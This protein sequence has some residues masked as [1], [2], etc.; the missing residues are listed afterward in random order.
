MSSLILLL[1]AVVAVIAV[2]VAVL[3]A[4]QPDRVKRARFLRRAGF[5]VMALSTLLVGVFAIGEA[6]DDPGGWEA[7]GLTAAW[8]LPLAALGTL[9]WFRPAWSVPVLAALTAAVI[10]L[11]VWFAVNPE[12]WRSFENRNG[13]I[14]DFLVLVLAAAIAVL[15]LKRTAI[16]G[17]LLLVLGVAPIAISSL[18]S[19]GGFGSLAVVS[20]APVVA[21]VLYLLAALPRSHPARPESTEAGPRDLPKAA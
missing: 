15:G 13:P 10:G 19:R 7:A 8:V 20:L 12:S 21:G 16:A 9:A 18:G 4:R 3:Y 17:A 2:P 6:F 11:S 1:A 5:T 14:R